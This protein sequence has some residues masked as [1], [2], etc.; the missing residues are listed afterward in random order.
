MNLNPAELSDASFFADDARLHG[1]ASSVVLEITDCASLADLGAVS[2]RVESLRARG[3]R[4]AIDGM[5]AGYSG[6]S[7]LTRLRPDVVK[8]DMSL[9]WNIHQSATHRAGVRSIT[10]LCHDLGFQVVAEG[11]ETAPEQDMLVTLGAGYVQG[12]L[13]A[14]PDPAVQ[15]PAMFE[16]VYASGS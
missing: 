12:Y 16:P 6:S 13:F 10:A 9:V 1:N 2:A 4:I 7:T 15:V 14:R 3:Y 5:G 11:V 8:L